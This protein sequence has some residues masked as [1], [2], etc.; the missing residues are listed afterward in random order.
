MPTVN[1]WVLGARPRTLPAAV[2]PV[3][4]GAALCIGEG[5][6]RWWR[7]ILALGVSLLLQIGV[8]YAND[9][10]DGVR[11]TDATRV[12]PTRLTASGLVSPSRVKRAALASFAVAAVLGLVLALVTSLWILV[13]GVAALLAGWFYT[14]GK[15]PY[16][17]FGLGELF[18]FVFFGLVA[19]VGTVFVV[20]ERIPAL[21][22]IL[23]TTVGALAC[24]L[25]VVNNLRDIPTDSVVGKRTL[26][27]RLGD[28][29]T[30]DLYVMLLIVALVFGVLGAFWNPGCSTIVVAIPVAI[31]PISAVRS[32]VTGADLI[33]VLGRTGRLQLVVGMA[34]SIGLAIAS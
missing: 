10:S 3:A 2:V 23:G 6:A 34:L 22:W 27:V 16:G 30:R 8:N 28:R 9:Y 11:G 20:V 17:Y 7:A 15:H 5:D 4:V 33:E 25:L 13:V 21:A 32:G 24:A 18:V 12:G 19:T 1:I 29:R 26:A 14:G 31:G